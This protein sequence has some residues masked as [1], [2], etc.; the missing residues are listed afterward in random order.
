M[1]IQRHGGI[2]HFGN[3]EGR[4]VKIWNPSVVYMVRIFSGIAQ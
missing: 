4:G 1:E 3:S 2:T